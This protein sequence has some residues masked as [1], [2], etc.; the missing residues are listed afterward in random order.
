[1]LATWPIATSTHAWR[2]IMNIMKA[3]LRLTFALVLLGATMSTAALASSMYLVQGIAGR[4][5][6]AATDPAFPVDV[7]FNDENCSQH[8]VPFGGVVGPFTFFAGTYNVKISV[9]NTLAPCSNS[10]LIDSEVT[11]DA[12]S[13]ISVVVALNDAG[14]PT[15]FTFKNTLTPVATNV[16]RVLF[17]DAADAPPVQVV[18][19]NLT[20]MK[21]Y[22]YTVN[23]GK[24]LDVNL[25]AGN[26]TVAVNQGTTS[27]VAPANITLFSQSVDLLYGLG[28][29][30]NNTV[31]LETKIMR[32]VI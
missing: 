4:N 27:L 11:I 8:G 14:A 24:L 26:Y 18:L 3:C 21:T 5:Y 28:Q 23:P 31:V 29:S 9:A 10:P 12:R 15:L 13:D 7:L 2:K 1:M 22:T 20:T 6:A 16:A 19:Q 17:A 25:P 30:K 32:D